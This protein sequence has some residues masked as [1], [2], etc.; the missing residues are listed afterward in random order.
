MQVHLLSW[1]I[2]KGVG[3]V[4]RRY[5]L[6]RTIELLRREAPDIALLQEV[7]KAAFKAIGGEVSVAHA[8]DDIAAFSVTSFYGW[9]WNWGSFEIR[10]WSTF[11]TPHRKQKKGA[12]KLNCNIR[13]SII[14]PPS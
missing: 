8:T 3:G 9:V 11:P 13:F 4:D 2:H 12:T 7:T 5:R 6:D 1:N 10:T 14:N